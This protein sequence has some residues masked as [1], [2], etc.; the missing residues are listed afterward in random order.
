MS[1]GR[2]LWALAALVRAEHTLIPVKLGDGVSV[3]LNV[4]ALDAPER[5]VAA[6]C[7]RWQVNARDCAELTA[8]VRTHGD[9]YVGEQAGGEGARELGHGTFEF[10]VDGERVAVPWVRR[11][12]CTLFALRAHDMCRVHPGILRVPGQCERLTAALASAAD[13]DARAP[14]RLFGEGPD[15]EASADAARANAAPADGRAVLLHVPKTAGNAAKNLLG[16]RVLRAPH[17]LAARENWRPPPSGARPPTKFL[18]VVREPRARFASAFA[19]LRTH[20]PRA[21]YLRLFF[22]REGAAAAGE[23]VAADARER[24]QLCA[25]ALDA[26]AP[27]HAVARH[28]LAWPQQSGDA[29]RSSALVRAR[30]SDYGKC[31]ACATRDARCPR[32]GADGGAGVRCSVFETIK[33]VEE[34]QG[35]QGEGGPTWCTDCGR[36]YFFAPQVAFLGNASWARL[37]ASSTPRHDGGQGGDGGGGDGDDDVTCLAT[38]EDLERGLR[39]CAAR[40]DLQ[41][42][43]APA[44]ELPR[45]N[46]NRAG[47]VKLGEACEAAVRVFYADDLRL[48]AELF[49]AL[50]FEEVNASSRRTGLVDRLDRLWRKCSE[51]PV[52]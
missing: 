15:D 6:F 48:Y 26:T 21:P 7:A 44:A 13:I 36:Y 45:V 18:A 14:C 32:D 12:P 39:R 23:D 17:C 20:L 11:E 46:V 41:P 9:I 31:D 29:G 22:A 16:A 1:I 8:L 5:E 38:V 30:S 37:D 3:T 43:L 51:T 25:A 49:D 2:V 47:A 50:R 42:P 4:S 34:M 19:Y 52:I 40:L 27:L 35:V 24:E 10:T 28:L 33:F